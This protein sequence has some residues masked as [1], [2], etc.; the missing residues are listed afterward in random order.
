MTSAYDG[1]LRAITLISA[2]PAKRA[3]GEL[4]V[5]GNGTHN[6]LLLNQ[7]PRRK[8]G[9]PPLG[10]GGEQVGCVLCT[11]GPGARWPVDPHHTDHS[12]QRNQCQS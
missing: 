11:N 7:L 9:L 2:N 1:D 4:L 5:T 3:T 6:M 10:Q 8:E 12:R